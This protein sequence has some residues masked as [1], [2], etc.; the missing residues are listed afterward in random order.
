MD[1]LVRVEKMRHAT[2]ISMELS[3]QL[4]THLVQGFNR[5]KVEVTGFTFRV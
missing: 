2:L 1:A 3:R 4:V 5:V